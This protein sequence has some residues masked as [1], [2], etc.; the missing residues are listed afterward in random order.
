MSHNERCPQEGVHIPYVRGMFR[1]VLAP[2]GQQQARLSNPAEQWYIN[3]HCFFIDDDQTIH[4]FGITNPYP[5]D[6]DYY[7]P[8][9]HRHIGHATAR[10]PLG[11]WAEHADAL[12]LPDGSQGNIGASFVVRRGDEYLMIY[13]YNTGFHMARWG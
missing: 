3:D 9:T 5:A 12:S 2:P 10:Q 4:W 8:G 7:G 1:H 11:P 6:D 13:G